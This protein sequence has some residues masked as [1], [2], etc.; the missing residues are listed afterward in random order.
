M[1]ETPRAAIFSRSLSEVADF[2]SF[3]T[4][5]LTQMTFG[6]SRDD[7]PKIVNMYLEKNLYKVD[8]FKVLDIEGVG[9]LI[10]ITKKTSKRD[11]EM[12]ICGE[13]AASSEAIKFAKE[14][15]LDYVS[16]SKTGIIKARLESAK[17]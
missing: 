1:I 15:G 10:S 2:Y 17:L 8:P 7:A 6:L 5:D 16:V 4:N 9:T 11:I 13:Q 14:L 3:G 12:G